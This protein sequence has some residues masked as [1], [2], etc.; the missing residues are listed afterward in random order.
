MKK[1]WNESLTN[2]FNGFLQEMVWENK[3]GQAGKL[4]FEKHIH[5]ELVGALSERPCSEMLRIRWK[6]GEMATVCC[7]AIDDRPY[8]GVWKPDFQIP[9]Y[10]SVSEPEKEARC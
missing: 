9:I 8:N 4:E 10:Q 1:G 2:H 6:L 7:R 5:G 3:E